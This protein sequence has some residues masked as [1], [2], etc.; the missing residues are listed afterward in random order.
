[1]ERPR[2]A[3]EIQT[4]ALDG[5]QLKLVEKVTIPRSRQKSGDMAYDSLSPCWSPDG[6]RL[7][8]VKFGSHAGIRIYGPEG[9]AVVKMPLPSPTA[10]RSD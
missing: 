10:H 6:I 1:V 8:L 9:G 5:S 7:A 2:Q 3:V 4:C